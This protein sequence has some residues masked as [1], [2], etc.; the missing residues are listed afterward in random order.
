[1]LTIHF[2][3][4]LCTCIIYF[5]NFIG[6][7]PI[8]F[9]R[10]SLLHNTLFS[11]L[12]FDAISFS[13]I[14]I[15][16]K[17][18]LILALF[19]KYTECCSSEM[20]WKKN[21]WNQITNTRCAQAIFYVHIAATKL[22]EF[23]FYISMLNVAFNFSTKKRENFFLLFPIEYYALF[24]GIIIIFFFSGHFMISVKLFYVFFFYF[25][26]NDIR[27]DDKLHMCAV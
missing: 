24:S 11:L 21:F 5:V 20:E 16:F 26:I 9:C 15:W 2:Q 7:F 18:I 4:I 1:M 10:L 25:F 12:Q 8:Y 14:S 3:F 23:K 13:R 27:F 17:W 22:H 6:W 19:L